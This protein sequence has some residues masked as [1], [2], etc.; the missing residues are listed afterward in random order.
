MALVSLSIAEQCLSNMIVSAFG[1]PVDASTYESPTSMTGSSDVATTDATT[2]VEHIKKTMRVMNSG[3]TTLDQILLMGRT[4]KDHKGL[5]FT[6]ERLETKPSA[7]TNVVTANIN[8][9]HTGGRNNHSSRRQRL[10]CYYCKK[11]GH[12]RRECSHFL[13]HQKV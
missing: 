1:L 6:E 7:I 13:M 12:I 8:H 10:R 5:G 3:T 11:L 9:Y 4:T 2:D